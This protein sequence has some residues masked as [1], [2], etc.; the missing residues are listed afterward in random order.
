MTSEATPP[1]IVIAK[2]GLDG[3]EVGARVVARGLVE[4]GVEVVYLGLRR[5]P[6]HIAEA[7]LQEDADAIGLSVLSGAHNYL[8][9]RVLELLHDNGA[10][11]VVVFGGG[12]IPPEDIAA[13]K[14]LGVK[15]LFGPGTSTQDII[16]FVQEHVRAAV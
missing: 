13:L 11:D 8:F 12:I 1:R 6:D 2:V 7:A 14:A 4:C 3:H 5:T 15:E 10:D 9:K 16:R